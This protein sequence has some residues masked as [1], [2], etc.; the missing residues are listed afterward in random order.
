VGTV[1]ADRD[2]GFVVASNDPRLAAIKLAKPNVGAKMKSYS[3]KID[4]FRI[5]NPQFL[6]Q[7]LGWR[8]IRHG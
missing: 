5:G 6:K 3:F 7:T 4:T 1:L 2:D 8:E